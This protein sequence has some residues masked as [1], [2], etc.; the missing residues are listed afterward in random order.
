M[1]N[2]GMVDYWR[3]KRLAGPLPANGHR[4][5][6]LRLRRT[7]TQIAPKLMTVHGD[8]RSFTRPVRNVRF[9]ETRTFVFGHREGPFLTQGGHSAMF[10]SA[11]VEAPNRTFVFVLGP[12]RTSQLSS[13]VDLWFGARPNA[14]LDPLYYSC[15]VANIVCLP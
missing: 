11:L 10:R 9:G 3:K 6:R 13:Q 2:N 15:P 8:S 5:F 14:R 12:N 4:R 7:T 1:R